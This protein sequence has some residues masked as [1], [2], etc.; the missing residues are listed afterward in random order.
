MEASPGIC[1]RGTSAHLVRHY[2]SINLSM[3]YSQDSEYLGVPLCSM[4][5][6]RNNDESVA[7]FMYSAMESVT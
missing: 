2:L 4:S 3:I 5:V 7:H 1:H 6:R